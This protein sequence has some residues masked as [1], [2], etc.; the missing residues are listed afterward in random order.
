MQLPGEGVPRI[1]RTPD[2]IK[3]KE[4]QW[5]RPI[6]A[7]PVSEHL[8]QGAGAR[9]H[10]PRQRNQAAEG[11][12]R[13]VRLIRGAAE[14]QRKPDGVQACDLDR[15]AGA[16]Y[17]PAV[18]GRRRRTR[19]GDARRIMSPRYRGSFGCSN[20][21]GLVSAPYWFGSGV[22]DAWRPGTG[23]AGIHGSWPSLRRARYRLRHVDRVGAQRPDPRYFLGRGKAE[24]LR[25][26]CARTGRATSSS[27]T[28]PCRRARSATSRSSS[29]GACWT[30]TG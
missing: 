4:L 27:S 30:A 28:T 3:N 29:S 16:Q 1:E 9:V 2:L 7:G 21:H 19:D 6:P 20:A 18:I 10:L 13:L 26:R 23:P 11:R 22:W 14:E 15:R 17:P 12:D 5:P 8:A 25:A 24:E